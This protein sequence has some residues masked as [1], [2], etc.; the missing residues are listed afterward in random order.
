MALELG[1]HM[2]NVTVQCCDCGSTESFVDLE[3]E[4]EQDET[5]ELNTECAQ[6]GA[7]EITVSAI[8]PIH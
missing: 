8:T 5:C 3:R 2:N 7:T 4:F 1:V 6:C